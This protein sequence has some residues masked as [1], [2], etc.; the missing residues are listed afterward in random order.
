MLEENNLQHLQAL[1]DVRS[2]EVCAHAS[3][4]LAV[5]DKHQNVM[6]RF[7][8]A[9]PADRLLQGN[10]CN[11]ETI[12]AKEKSMRRYTEPETGATLTYTSSLVVLAHYVSCLAYLDKPKIP[13]STSTDG[14]E[15][16]A[17]ASTNRPQRDLNGVMLQPTYFMTMENKRYVCEVVLPEQA[18]VRSA[19][20]KP[21]SNK[22]IAKRSAAFEMCIRLRKGDHLDGNLISTLKRFIPA[23]ANALL[24]VN[25]KKRTEYGARLKPRLWEDSR[26]Y[27]IS[28]CILLFLFRPWMLETCLGSS[29][30]QRLPE[31]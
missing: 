9:L 10:D 26:G 14:H 6:R 28:D 7:C 27:V 11:L 2:G 18:P 25:L 4:V 29:L 24:A 20:G 16:P 3:S 21:S 13:D 23:N 31:N 22:A 17:T 1:N 15:T 19:V 5:T 8:E 12:L 30:P